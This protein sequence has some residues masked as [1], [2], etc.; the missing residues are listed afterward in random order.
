MRS[1]GMLTRREFLKGLG[2]GLALAGLSPGLAKLSF[3]ATG[4]PEI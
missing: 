3:G 1:R 2:A 4:C